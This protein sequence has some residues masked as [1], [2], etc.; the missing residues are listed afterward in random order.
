MVKIKFSIFEMKDITSLS[1]EK[2]KNMVD[3]LRSR[4]Y[5]RLKALNKGKEKKGAEGA[6]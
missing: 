3:T 6:N 4:R 5:N 1:E 2:L